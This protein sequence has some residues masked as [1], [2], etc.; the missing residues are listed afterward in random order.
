VIVAEGNPR[1]DFGEAGSIDLEDVEILAGVADRVDI[2]SIRTR[3]DR[4]EEAASFNRA[5]IGDAS[6][7]VLTGVAV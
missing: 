6:K 7:R 3:G 5:D 1:Q 2:S 4:F